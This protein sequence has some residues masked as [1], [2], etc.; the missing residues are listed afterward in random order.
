MDRIEFVCFRQSGRHV[1]EGPVEL[2]GGGVGA[3]DLPPPGPRH[4]ADVPQALGVGRGSSDV[5]S[6]LLETFL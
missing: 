3:L 1:R 2:T 6:C 5:S 4:G